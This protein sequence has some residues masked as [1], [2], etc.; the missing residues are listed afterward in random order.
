MQ[1]SRT[2]GSC[3]DISGVWVLGLHLLPTCSLVS[4]SCLD[5]GREVPVLS[6]CS[7]EKSHFRACPY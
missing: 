3:G 5:E 6:G 1:F 2:G 4:S 7:E